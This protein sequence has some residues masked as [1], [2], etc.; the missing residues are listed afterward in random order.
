MGD[1]I[2][3]MHVANLN[4]NGVFSAIKTHFEP[5]FLEIGTSDRN[6]MDVELLPAFPRGFLV[7][8]EPLVDKYARGLTRSKNARK[9][10]D[11]YEELGKHHERGMILPLA[12]GPTA[13]EHGQF[14]AFHVGSNAGCSSILNVSKAASFGYWCRNIR[15]IRQVWT[16]TLEKLMAMIDRKIEFLKI[17]AQGMDLE[18]VKSGRTR[19]DDIKHIGM[20]VISDDCNTLYH[21]QPKCSYVLQEMYKIGFKPIGPTRC[22]PE[23]RR[24]SYNHY[25]ELE[26]VF[27]HLKH[28]TNPK[29]FEY[30]NLHYNGC[31]NV[32]N[33]TV[34][35]GLRYKFYSKHTN[36]YYTHNSSL[37]QLYRCPDSCQGKLGA[38]RCP[39][40]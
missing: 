34:T 40:G 39:W 22:R 26:V 37:G 27:V 17:D 8:V 21:K 12:I 2:A 24:T 33:I 14:N 1:F 29:F 3:P 7:S 31:S 25:C 16:I 15:E 19:L 13:T 38:V 5:V 32:S 35:N 36:K 10:R 4:K 28:V 30:H 23:F 9:V 20:E 18:I 6:T 11:A